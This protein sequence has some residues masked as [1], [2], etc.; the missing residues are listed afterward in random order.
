MKQGLFQKGSTRSKEQR[1]S[2]VNATLLAN[3]QT[4]SGEYLMGIVGSCS[5]E[6]MED[7][8]EAN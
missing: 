1:P 2:T 5:L 8:E 6:G 3:R 7:E 4:G